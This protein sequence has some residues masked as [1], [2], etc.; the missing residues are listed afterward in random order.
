[1]MN[2]KEAELRR[3]LKKMNGGYCRLS[4]LRSRT[5]RCLDGCE[6]AVLNT[7][8]NMYEDWGSIEGLYNRWVI[9]G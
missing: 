9:R 7:Y 5:S 8:R 1:M 2:F 3:A 6:Y 4:K